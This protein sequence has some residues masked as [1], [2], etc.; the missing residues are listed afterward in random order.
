ML[1][2]DGSAGER[3]ATDIGDEGG[4]VRGTTVGLGCDS[5]LEK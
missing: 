5:R 2:V 1:I 4:C 3:A